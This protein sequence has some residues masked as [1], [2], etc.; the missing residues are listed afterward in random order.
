MRHRAVRI[1]Q[2]KKR[3]GN[4]AISGHYFTAD[5]DMIDDEPNGHHSHPV[6]LGV[7]CN[8]IAGDDKKHGF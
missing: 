3:V 8:I 5:C 4:P 2:R 1:D 6:G 7:F